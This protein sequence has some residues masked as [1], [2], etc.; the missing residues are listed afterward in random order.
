MKRKVKA[1]GSIPQKGLRLLLNG[2]ENQ[3]ENGLQEIRALC[4]LF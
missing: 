1:S 2:V 3:P 4:R